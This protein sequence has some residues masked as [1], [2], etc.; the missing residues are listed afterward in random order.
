MAKTFVLATDVLVSSLNSTLR[1][2]SD[3][4][5]VIP[6]S[7]LRELQDYRGKPENQKI[8]V[9]ILEYV[10]KLGPKELIGTGVKQCNNSILRIARNQADI[11]D[12]LSVE[13]LTD[14]DKKVLQACLGI[15]Q[16]ERD[17]K[18]I[19]VS[20]RP[21]LRFVATSLGIVAEDFKDDLF[22]PPQGQY[23]GRLQVQVSK[24]S[25]DIFFKENALSI[26]QILDYEEIEWVQNI[27]VEMKAFDSDQSAL[28]RFDGTQIVS[29]NFQPL[30]YPYGIA[31]KNVGQRIFM[32]CL[33]TNWQVAPLVIAKGC[34]GTGKTFCSLAAALNGVEI[35]E[36]KRI[37]VATPSETVGNERLGFLPGDIVDKVS[38]YLGGIKDNLSIL[39]NLKKKQNKQKED[40]V[41]KAQYYLESGLIEIQPIGFIRG[42]TIVDTLFIID[43]TQNIDPGDIKD[44]V[45]RAGEGSKFIFLGDPTQV[46]NPNLN[47]RY[48]GLVYLSEKMKGNSLCWQVTLESKESVRSELSRIAGQIL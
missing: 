13:D 23:T 21:L 8:A 12:T 17:K 41:K 15:M 4:E 34:A 42:R 19:L 33:L 31:A 7:V 27:F 10:E 30:Q 28:G 39:L 29:R 2:D 32:E 37:L 24:E 48:N 38:P 5:V 14:K 45:T 1:F 11:P 9:G 36:Y 43:E 47:E 46:N 25:I 44:I 3:N 35:G 18:V 26:S 6:L 16:E 40:S 22:P 20:K